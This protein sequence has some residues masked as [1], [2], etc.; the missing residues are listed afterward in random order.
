MFI[1]IDI[2]LQEEKEIQKQQEENLTRRVVNKENKENEEDKKEEIKISTLFSHES[3]IFKDNTGYVDPNTY[4]LS[5]FQRYNDIGVDEMQLRDVSIYSNDIYL[6]S[7][8]ISP[9]TKLIGIF[10]MFLSWIIMEYFDY[11]FIMTKLRYLN[12][13]FLVFTQENLHYVHNLDR[14]A[15]LKMNLQEMY[16]GSFRMP[17]LNHPY[18]Q[19]WTKLTIIYQI[20]R[21]NINEK[22]ILIKINFIKIFFKV[23]SKISV[24]KMNYNKSK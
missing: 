21:Y 7:F 5:A 13:S 19:K 1:I 15:Y 3:E 24:K 18:Y 11:R 12:K 9:S 20:C 8:E 23:N 14:K 10:R 4:L 17:L 6:N 22:A 16:D 2:K